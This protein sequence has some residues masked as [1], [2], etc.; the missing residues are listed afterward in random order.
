MLG[1]QKNSGDMWTVQ[2]LGQKNRSGSK[3]HVPAAC[4]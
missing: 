3:S 2:E 1:Q 4:P